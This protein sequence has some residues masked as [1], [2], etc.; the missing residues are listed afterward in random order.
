MRL[1]AGLL[2]ALGGLASS[3]MAAEDCVRRPVGLTP[4]WLPAAAW[5]MEGDLLLAADVAGGRILRFG[6]TGEYLGDLSRPGSEATSFTKPTSLQAVSDGF[7]LRDR[8]FRWLLLDSRGVPAKEVAAGDARKLNITASVL[9]AGE[10]HGLGT[11]TEGGRKPE[12][13]FLRVKL[14]PLS[15]LEVGE[16]IDAE[17]REMDFHGLLGSTIAEAGGEPFALRFTELPRIERLWPQRALKSFP[18][19]F[20]S[21]PA[22]PQPGGPGEAQRRRFQALEKARM[23]VALL[24]QAGALFVITREPDGAGRTRWLAHRI[25]LQLDRL[26]APVRLPTHAAHLLIA[27]GPRHWAILE[28]SSLTAEGFNTLE[29]VVLVPTSWLT[30]S[31]SPLKDLERESQCPRP[32]TAQ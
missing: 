6:P 3:A 19:G 28:E 27:P 32:A 5:G 12:F 15:V 11:T 22:L 26:A 25:D 1:I 23:P 2:L 7:L 31:D 14:E 16:T 9:I 17:A 18:Q 20:S 30:A 21:L 24:G 29:A 4:V 8:V 13:R 10:L